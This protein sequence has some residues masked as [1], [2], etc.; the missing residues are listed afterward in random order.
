MRTGNEGSDSTGPAKQMFLLRAFSS[1][2]VLALLLT[3]CATTTPPKLEPRIEAP[4]A[5]SVSPSPAEVLAQE[6]MSGQLVTFGKLR[7]VLRGKEVIIDENGSERQAS[8]IRPEL[9]QDMVK[10]DFRIFSGAVLPDSDVAGI[11]RETKAHLVVTIDAKSEI[12]NSTGNFSKYRASAEVKAIRGHDGTIL[13]EARAEAMGPRQQDSDRAGQLALRSLTPD[14][15][16]QLLEGLLGK[17]DQLLWAGLIINSVQSMDK[18]LAIQ[19][20]IESKSFVSYVELLNWDRDTQ[21]ATFEIIYGTKHESDVALLL[22]D[23]PHVK[24]R[25]TKYEPGRMEVLR[26][27]MTGYK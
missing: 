19:R 10:R 12:V 7:T 8:E 3:G 9:E 27:T 16:K 18:A 6:D 17:T 20:G 23:I 15:S 21:V 5:A 1:V 14:L 24:V 4:P 22:N 11:T 26:K 25:P 2:A 13:A